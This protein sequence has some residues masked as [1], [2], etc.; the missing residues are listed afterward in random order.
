MSATA[1]EA[2]LVKTEKTVKPV[3]MFPTAV[4]KYAIWFAN[5]I[6]QL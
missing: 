1:A 5:G 3:R 2:F 6:C 4:Q